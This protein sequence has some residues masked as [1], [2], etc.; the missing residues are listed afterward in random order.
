MILTNDGTVSQLRRWQHI[1][2]RPCAQRKP[3]NK[4]QSVLR[5]HATKAEEKVL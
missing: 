4:N 3:L 2:Q 1:C 5:Q